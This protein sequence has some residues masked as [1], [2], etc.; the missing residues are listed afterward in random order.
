MECGLTLHGFRPLHWDT[1]SLAS[2]F[3]LLKVEL[4]RVPLDPMGLPLDPLEMTDH[5]GKAVLSLLSI[6]SVHALNWC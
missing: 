6:S 5:Q 3:M 1:A 4:L 2:S